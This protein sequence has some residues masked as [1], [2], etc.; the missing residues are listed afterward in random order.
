MSGVNRSTTTPRTQAPTQTPRTEQSQR[1]QPNQTTQQPQ[2]SR[3]TTSG[4]VNATSANGSVGYETGSAF[5]ARTSGTL[6]G[7]VQAEAHV[8]GPSFSING[9]AD[10]SVGVGGIDVNLSVDVNATLLEAGASATKT[11]SVE[12]GGEQIDVTVDLSAEGMVGVDGS[13]NLDI[14]IGTDGQVSVNAGAE[15]F[16]GARG[17]LTG[18]ISVAHEGREVASGQVELSGTAGV[19]FDAH[20]NIEL[21]DEGLSF[22]VGAEASPTVGFGVDISGNVNGGNTARLLG[23]VLGGL[24]EEGVEWAGD[25]LED[26]G[27]WAADRFE[28]VGDFIS[29]IIPD[30]DL[31]PWN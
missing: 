26:V 6:P 29:D 10:A 20:A 21:T 30:I 13:L 15:G 25:K 17:S 3:V 28:D 8:A 14:H 9:N 1:T 7:G 22:D 11:F 24:A 19:G 18:G 16:A 31:T 5:E 4:D 27:D 2:Q 12:V 23:E